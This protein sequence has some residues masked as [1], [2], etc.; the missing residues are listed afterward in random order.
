MKKYR[1]RS[2]RRFLEIDGMEEKVF[3]LGARM[4]G[5]WK[6]PPDQLWEAFQALK[7]NMRPV[8]NG[9]ELIAFPSFTVRDGAYYPGA[10]VY[11]TQGL[12]ELL[13]DIPEYDKF[14][15]EWGTGLLRDEAWGHLVGMSSGER[16]AVLQ[17][18]RVMPDPVRWETVRD[19]MGILVNG[20]RVA[21]YIVAWALAD[22]WKRPFAYLPAMIGPLQPGD[23]RPEAVYEAVSRYLMLSVGS[24]RYSIDWALDVLEFPTDDL[25]ETDDDLLETDDDDDD[26]EE[27]E[28]E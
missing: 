17:K 20:P 7:H 26:E 22:R 13:L 10:A 19:P 16:K 2:L 27:E 9:V 25:L 18:G 3:Y 23:S 24:I 28:E 21:A 4:L 12:R 14:A 8:E 6:T 15:Y 11:S 1:T 5:Y